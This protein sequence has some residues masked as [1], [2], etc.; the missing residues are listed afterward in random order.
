MRILTSAP[1]IARCF[2]QL[3]RRHTKFSMAV[4]WASVNFPAYDLLLDHKT[5]VSRA[6]VGLHF[7]QT[8]PDFIKEFLNDT[9]VRYIK[10]PNGVF[11]PKVYLFETGKKSWACLIGSGNFTQGGFLANDEAIILIESTDN[12]DGSV[13]D[14]LLRAIRGY[15][16]KAEPFDQT[17]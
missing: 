1:K 4:A 14:R 6:I 3:L 17:E 16:R 7:C 2:E 5:K 12:P 11:H 8:H 15:W 9:R 10:K 13:R